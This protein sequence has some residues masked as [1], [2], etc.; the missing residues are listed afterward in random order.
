M[1][2][3]IIILLLTLSAGIAYA[4]DLWPDPFGDPEGTDGTQGVGCCLYECNVAM[5]GFIADC[6][7]EFGA[8]NLA[9]S[10][11]EQ[12]QAIDE[13]IEDRLEDCYDGCYGGRE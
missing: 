2:K 1:K 9:Q 5:S 3:N 7:E 8:E 13:C 4:C 12:R 6:Q 11:P 10:T